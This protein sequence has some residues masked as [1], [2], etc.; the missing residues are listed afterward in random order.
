MIIDQAHRSGRYSQVEIDSLEFDGDVPSASDLAQKWKLMLREAEKLIDILPAEHVGDCVLD[1]N[2][3][4]ILAS[5][6][7]LQ[8]LLDADKIIWHS[9]SL[10]GAYPIIKTV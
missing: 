10:R 4:L 2:G 3:N 7:D 8:Q 1:L 9:G 6:Q 5:N